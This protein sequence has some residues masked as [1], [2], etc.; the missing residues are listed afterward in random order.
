LVLAASYYD[1]DGH[2]GALTKGDQDGLDEVAGDAGDV[3]PGR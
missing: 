3:E 1:L 2:V